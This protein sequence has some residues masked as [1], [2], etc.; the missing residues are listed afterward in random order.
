MRTAQAPN[1]KLTK[2]PDPPLLSACIVTHYA[3]TPYHAGR[4]EVVKMCLDTMI[5]GM[6]EFDYELLIWDN[7][8]TPEFKEFI[9]SYNPH[10][11]VESVNVGVHNARYH[12]ANLARG[13]ILAQA[14]D[15]ILFSPDWATLQIQAL[16]TFN[17]GIVSGSPYRYAF[18]WGQTKIIPDDIKVKRGQYIPEQ[19]IRDAADSVGI[20]QI[21]Y[22]AGTR[23]TQDVLLEKDGVQAWNHG[24]HIQFMGK[25]EIARNFLFPEDYYL[26]DGKRFNRACEAAGMLQVTTFERTAIHIG[27]VVD[28]R[29]REIHKDWWNG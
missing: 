13:E 1:K 27:N 21:S 24:H 25:R 16:R 14:D 19:W 12:L 8:S 3:D 18:N 11:L 9:R 26:A 6:K 28:P 4:M 20:D 15:D 2:L 22:L 23:S 10:V 17:A 5:G 29:I 7:G